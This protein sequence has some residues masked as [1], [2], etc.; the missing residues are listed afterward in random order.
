MKERRSA[1]GVLVATHEGKRQVG[2]Y[3][4]K[5]EDNIKMDLYERRW[6][7]KWFHIV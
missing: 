2:R 7:V 4:R 3:M 6:G 1:H 5:W